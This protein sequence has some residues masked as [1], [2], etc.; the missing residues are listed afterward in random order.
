MCAF[1]CLV[2][3]VLLLCQQDVT[4]N[5]RY[6]IQHRLPKGQ[7]MDVICYIIHTRSCQSLQKCEPQTE[8]I[9]TQTR[10]NEMK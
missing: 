3:K 1:T 7:K 5:N 2:N 6:L 8:A 9:I 4:L 10:M